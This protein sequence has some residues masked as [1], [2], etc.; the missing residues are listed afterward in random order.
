MAEDRPIVLIQQQHLDQFCP[1]LRQLLDLELARG[2]RI[3]ETGSGWP[4]ETTIL[5]SLQNHFGP[6]PSELPPGVEFHEVND[7]H[8]WKSEYFHAP[9]GH[10]LICR[11]S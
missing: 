8:W 10:L 3:F 4:R 9:T 6:M 5:V 7:P 2:N 1:E 11:F